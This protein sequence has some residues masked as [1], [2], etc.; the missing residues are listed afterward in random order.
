MK[1]DRNREAIA[2]L[3]AFFRGAGGQGVVAL[4]DDDVTASHWRW[5]RKELRG[6]QRLLDEYFAPLGRAFP[7]LV[8]EVID[9]VE[10]TYKVAIRGEFQATFANEWLGLP[11]HGRRV[12]WRAHDIYEFRDGKIV[13][14][15]L[16]NDTLTVARQLGALPDDGRPW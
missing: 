16:G 13:R 8:F 10:G 2:K 11:P 6:K 5:G 9:F 14:I 4:L 7:D 1:D 3:I 12:S 15:W